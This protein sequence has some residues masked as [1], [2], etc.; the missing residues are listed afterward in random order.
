LNRQANRRSRALGFGLLE[1]IVALTILAATGAAL[2]AWISQNLQDAARIEAAQARTALQMS[3]RGLMGAINPFTEPEGT[4]SLGSIRVQ[5]RSKPVAP[6]RAS[7]PTQ[8]MEITR[9]RVGL[10][11]VDVSAS[12]EVSGAQA[13]FK[14]LQTGLES[15]AGAQK[16]SAGDPP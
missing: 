14:M 13:S 3:A 10:Y 7:V 2:F 16:S 15:L 1:A 9:W 4:R 8:P 6:L 11:E 5:W 12:D